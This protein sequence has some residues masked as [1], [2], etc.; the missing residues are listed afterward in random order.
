MKIV[1]TAGRVERFERRYGRRK[2]GARGRSGEPEAEPATQGRGRRRRV[3]RVGRRWAPTSGPDLTRP[4]ATRWAATSWSCAL[5]RRADSAPG[6]IAV[7][8]TARPSCSARTSTPVLARAGPCRT[9]A[10][11][12]CRPTPAAALW[13]SWTTARRPPPGWP[14]YFRCAASRSRSVRAATSIARRSPGPAA[15][16]ARPAPTVRTELLDAAAGRSDLRWWSRTA[17]SAARS[18]A[19]RWHGS[20]VW[21]ERDRWRR[22]AATWRPASVGS[23]ATPWPR[24]TRGSRRRRASTRAVRTV[25]AAP[26]RPGAPTHPLQLLAASAGC[27]SMVVA[28]PSLVG[29]RRAGRGRHD[30]RARRASATT[31]R[32]LRSGPTSTV[33]PVLVVVLAP[34]CDLDLVPLAADT[35]GAGTTPR[36]AW[37]S[38]C[39]SVTTCQPPIDAGWACC[40][41][42]AELV[43]VTPG[44]G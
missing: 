16:R 10:P 8:R 28:D 41:A 22:R 24:C 2:G 15:G 5:G 38:R 3:S 12:H 17:S 30:H 4:G 34:A 20:C 9:P 42:T 37:W 23:T 6:P 26:A 11:V 44:W 1:D 33:A 7:G 27:A 35:R 18:S 21:P 19:S 14:R 31:C 13:C 25:R 29:A 32:R 36:P 43:D 40:G 39:R